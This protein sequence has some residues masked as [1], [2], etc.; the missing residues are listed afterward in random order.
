MYLK[1]LEIGNVKLKNNIILA[2]MAGITD[3]PFRLICKKYNP[4]LMY[5][6]MVSSRA[7]CYNDEKTLKMIE[8]EENER[9]TA[10]QIFGNDPKMM[11]EAAKKLSDVADIIDINMGCP[12]PKV[13]KGGDG[14]AL[15]QNLE[16][17]DSIIKEVVEQSRVPV[18]V[19]MRKGF[20]SDNVVAIELAK[21]CERNG[22][23][24]ITVHGRS[25]DEFYSGKV[26]LDIIKQVKKSIS[27]PV[28][29]NGDIFSEEDAL[30]MFEYTGVDGIMCA[31]GTLGSPWIF[32]SVIDY[33]QT[34][35]KNREPSNEEKLKVILEHI[36]LAMQNKG[37]YTAV[38]EMRKHIAWYTKG[39]P[40]ATNIRECVNKIESIQELKNTL[41]DFFR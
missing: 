10:I 16:L 19:K 36:D 28:I 33:L 13:V 30:R 26:D 38:R 4:G 1:E 7:I 22:V 2:P 12:A 14:S 32:R 20:S 17:A 29:G 25:R 11:G 21:I 40:K 18:S 24:A 27:I 6:E 31:R 39:M 35:E 8:I 5:T 41:M 3:L 37:E 9:P 34:G 23:S 15:L